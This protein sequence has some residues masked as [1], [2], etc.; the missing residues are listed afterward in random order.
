MPGG[1][2]KAQWHD[3]PGENV[4]HRGATYSTGVP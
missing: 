4:N 2:L 1:V 3:S